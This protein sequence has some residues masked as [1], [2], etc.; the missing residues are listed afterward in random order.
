[1]ITRDHSRKT[2]QS[3]M[4]QIFGRG[5]EHTARHSSWVI[6]ALNIVALEWLLGLTDDALASQICWFET[7]PSKFIP[8]SISHENDVHAKERRF[9]HRVELA[10]SYIAMYGKL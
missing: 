2:Y 9:F 5:E 10:S 8:S 4:E 1:M 7:D 3:A 6:R